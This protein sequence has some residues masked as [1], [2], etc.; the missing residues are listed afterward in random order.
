MDKLAEAKR[1]MIPENGVI[2]QVQAVTF[3]EGESVFDV[4][5]R[6]LKKKKIHLEFVNN[7]MYNSAYIEGIG[8]LYEFDCGDTS[9]WIYKVNG[10]E[11]RYGC[12][13]YKLKSGDAIEFLYRCS[14]FD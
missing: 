13:Q 7:P 14:M 11:P 2:F 4:L 5:L 3:S 6:E 12:S 9:G 1:G 10:V 8:N